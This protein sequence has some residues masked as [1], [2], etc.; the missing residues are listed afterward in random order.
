MKE[1]AIVPLHP[2]QSPPVYINPPSPVSSPRPYQPYFDRR[3]SGSGLGQVY[4]ERPP[5]AQGL[6]DARKDVYREA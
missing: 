1:A 4:G 5:S 3:P 6:R 2:M